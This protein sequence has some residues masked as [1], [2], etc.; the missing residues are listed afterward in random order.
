MS[1]P[2]AA[3]LESALDFG[4]IVLPPGAEVLGVL[5]QRGI[6]Q[7]YALAVALGPDTVD[8]LLRASGFGGELEPG[9]QVFLPPVPGFDPDRGT[10]IASAQDALPA[11][12]ARRARVIREVLVD[13]GELGRPIVHI[14]LFTT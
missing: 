1:T 4:G 8:G 12:R 9:R 3:A 14:W 13:R 7:L 6:D 10:D 2:A 5:D 11:G